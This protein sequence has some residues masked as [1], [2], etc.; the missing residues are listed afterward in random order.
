MVAEPRVSASLV[1]CAIGMAVG[2][3]NGWA[4]GTAIDGAW[5]RR[6]ELHIEQTASRV[7]L[8]GMLGYWY[9]YWLGDWAW[10]IG[11]AIGHGYWLGWPELHR[12]RLRLNASADGLG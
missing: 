12:R 9:G 3:A 7:G 6:L 10:A 2:C 5:W 8:A 1:C 4:I 11:T